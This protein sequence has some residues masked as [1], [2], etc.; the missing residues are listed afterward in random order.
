MWTYNYSN[1][2]YHHGIL[3]MKWG[4]RNGTPYPLCSSAHS[5]SEKR[6]GWQKSLSKVKEKE[7]AYRQ[8]LTNISENKNADVGDLRR[9]RYRNQNLSKRVAKMTASGVTQFCIGEI[10]SGQIEKYRLV[11]K[12]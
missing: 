5:L 3:G 11:S 9:I 6:A 4:Q 7:N 8:K 10:M 1:E 2:L 12:N